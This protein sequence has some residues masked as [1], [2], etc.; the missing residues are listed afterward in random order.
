M[1]GCVPVVP[2][3]G[4]AHWQ[5]GKI[6]RHGQTIKRM[7]EN[8]VRRAKVQGKDDMGKMALE[9]AQAKNELVREHGWS[10]NMLVFGREPRVH[11]EI[12]VEGNPVV[13]HPDVGKTG[14]DVGKHIRYRYHA[15][16]SY[17]RHQAKRM[18]LQ[19]VEQRTR[20][21]TPPEQ[22]QMVFF[23]REVK[24]RRKQEPA[25]NWVG[26]GFVVG[27]QGNTVWVACGGRCY[28]VASEH[29]RLAMGDEQYY[30]LPE[31]QEAI[32][33]FRRSSPDA[34]FED[35]TKQ[36]GPASSDLSVDEV[37][38]NLVEDINEDEGTA[39]NQDPITSVEE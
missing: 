10:P 39:V 24:I 19:T 8:V 5:A 16:M 23:W 12:H 7:M 11:G 9:T 13:F 28:L 21:G 30:G 33:L 4:T 2:I 25:S 31:I 22:G 35:L 6:E 29:V 34:T 14:S 1:E 3:A 26:P 20:R 18:V 38:I 17:I 15:R 36:S 27:I 32:S 37:D